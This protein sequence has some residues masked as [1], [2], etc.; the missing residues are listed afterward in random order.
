[1]RGFGICGIWYCVE[2]KLHR[3]WH[4]E[5]MSLT[6][7][8][9]RV[10]RF[11]ASLTLTVFLS[12]GEAHYVVKTENVSDTGLYLRSKEMFP[13]GTQLHLV[14]GQPPE[15]PRLRA[16]GIVRWSEGGKGFGLEF[17]SISV[18]DRLTLMR[19]L[20]SQSHCEQA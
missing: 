8:R 1:M 16:E 2:A 15:L 6:D 5:S 19:F 20:N 17:T 9:R 7:E 10:P 13:V 14:F 18:D 4:P 11:I 3:G 12:D